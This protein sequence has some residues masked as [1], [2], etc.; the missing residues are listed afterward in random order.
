MPPTSELKVH[1]PD[2]PQHTH[3][4]TN[5]PRDVQLQWKSAYEK[6][7]LSAVKSGEEF[8]HSVATSAANRLLDVKQPRSH[9][10]ALAIP[11]WQVMK[12]EE[13]DYANLPLHGRIALRDAGVTTTDSKILFVCTTDGKQH[14]FPLPGKKTLADL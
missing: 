6:A 5:V 13:I 1:I 4:L 8:P 9:E 3:A 7:Y 11:D 12:R 14:F 2:P 10:E